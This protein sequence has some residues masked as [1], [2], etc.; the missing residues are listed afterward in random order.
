MAGNPERFREIE[1][2]YEAALNLGPEERRALLAQADSALRRAVEALLALS[3]T[4]TETLGRDSASAAAPEPVAAAELIAIGSQLGPYSIE[5]V[6]G[7]G[8][9]GKVYRAMDTR[10]GRKVA[11]KV[12]AQKFG[13]R[14]EREARAISALNHPHICTLYDVGALP[15]GTGYLVTELVEGETLRDWI[16][17]SP[18]IEGSIEI[19]KQVLDGLRAA[20]N[21]G[22]VHRDLKPQNIMVRFDGYAKVLDFGLAKWMPATGVLGTP[23][24]LSVPGQ[25]L[26]TVAYMSPE[27]VLGQETDPRSDL[28]SFGIILYEML[29]GRHPWPQKSAVDLMHAI[30]HDDPAPIDASPLRGTALVSVVE[31]LL[32]KNPAE[33]YRSAE[34]V[35]E[36]LGRSP[37]EEEGRAARP[38]ALTRVIVLPFRILRRHEASD[39]LSVSLPDAI[40]S[41]LAAIDSLVVR[42]TLV[43]SR[44]A[45]SPNLDPKTIAEQAQVDAILAGTMLSDG[46]QLRVNTQL[47]KA[48]DGTV[49]WSDTSQVS[50]RDIFQLQDSLV[51]RIVQSLKLPLTAHERDALKH[52]VPASPIAYEYYLRANQI[53]AISDVQNMTQNMILARDL[54]LAC[55]NLDPEYAPAW[56]CLGRTHRFVGKF[57]A[58]D[59]SENFALAEEAFRKAFALTPE[60]ALAHNF[61]TALETDLGR[62][63]DAMRRLLKR[64]HTHHNDPNLFAGLVQAC[65][66]CDLLEASVAAHDRAKRLDPNVPTSVAYTYLHLGDFQRALDSCGLADWYVRVTSLT[67]LGR[68]KEAIEEARRVEKSNMRQLAAWAGAYR[69]YLEGD[70]IKGLESLDQELELT[71]LRTSDPEARFCRACLLAKLNEPARTLEFLSMALDKGYRCHYAI[72][73]D[74]WLNSLRSHHQFTEMVNRA[75]AM[76]LQARTV[77]LENGGDRLLKVALDNKFPNPLQRG[78]ALSED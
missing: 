71:A 9:M 28:F 23:S 20:H 32:R 50:L 48:S 17:H 77:F 13:G 27:Q 2:L 58:G 61:Y 49:L 42:S 45:A 51:D 34:E 31:R 33:R 65:R 73:Q 52:D 3:C 63:L 35:L 37:L 59:E 41:S 55:V 67:A 6:L 68:T 12:A 69:A 40:S 24:G 7:V 8:G 60:S 56:A 18:T 78:Q 19:A 29:M 62:S 47:I 14:F 11:I 53:V 16:K 57:G 5:A 21:A 15:S 30:V 54:Y 75:A 44:F 64:A 25:I 36:N 22:I 66:Y 39:F 43:A 1:A 10:L 46:E 74:R 38:R 76:S 4:D 70:P 26:G 72:L